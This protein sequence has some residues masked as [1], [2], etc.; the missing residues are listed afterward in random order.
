MTFQ[1]RA[2]EGWRYWWGL[3]LWLVTPPSSPTFH[4]QRDIWNTYHQM[5]FFFIVLCSSSITELL[6]LFNVFSEPPLSLYRV[7]TMQQSI[8]LWEGEWQDHPQKQA[9]VGKSL[10]ADGFLSEE[11]NFWDGF[12]KLNNMIS[13][14]Y[15]FHCLALG[16]YLSALCWCTKLYGF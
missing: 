14:T 10:C 9:I 2:K 1:L 6:N 13:Q 4:N 12:D 15:I 16:V 11:S 7:F 8:I 3:N 5:C